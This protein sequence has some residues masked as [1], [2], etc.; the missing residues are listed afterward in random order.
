MI[1]ILSILII[2]FLFFGGFSVIG[3]TENI[4]DNNH[5]SFENYKGCLIDGPLEEWNKTY[6]G[7]YRDWLSYG[8]V[9]NDNS[10]VAKGCRDFSQSYRNGDGWI[11]KINIA[12]NL[13]WEKTI[14]GDGSDFCNG[15][16]QTNN[17]GYV[18]GFTTD[19]F[20]SG[21]FDIRL[22]KTDQEF[23]EEWDIL[24]TSSYDK[25]A[26]NF[27]NANDG[28]F[29]MTG[30]TTN[31]DDD[32]DLLII[33][34]DDSGNEEWNRIF[35]GSDTDG[36]NR[37]LQTDDNGYIVI[38]YTYSYG[39]GNRD[40]WIIKLD[41]A[42][43]E[44]WKRTYGMDF[45]DGLTDIKKTIDGGY[46]ILGSKQLVDS[47]DD[48][49]L[50]KF[51]NEW[52]LEWEQI[53]G[54][55]DFNEI[56]NSIQQT[57]DNGFIITGNHRSAFITG[58][59]QGILL[60]TD[61][62]GVV[63]W[64]KLFGGFDEDNGRYVIQTSDD[65]FIVIGETKSYGSGDID[66]WIVKF[67]SFENQRPNIPSRPSGETNGRTGEE[68][69]Y[70][71]STIDPDGDD[72]YYLFDWGNGMTS[73]IQGPYASGEECSSAGIWF[74]DGNY[75]IKVKAID[76]H[77]AES[78]WSDPLIVSMPKSKKSLINN[79]WYY[80][81]KLQNYAPKGMPDFDQRQE[82]W[83]NH[84]GMESF[85]GPTAVSNVLW[86]IDSKYSDPKGYPGDGIDNYPLVQDYNAPSNP[87]PGPLSDDHNF[88]NVNDPATPWD[89]VNYTYGN[90]F[91]EKVAWYVDN[92]GVKTGDNHL[93]A[94]SNGI[95]DGIT[96]WIQDVGLS[97]SFDIIIHDSTRKNSL[98]EIIN[99][100]KCGD[101]IILNLGFYTNT[102]FLR[103]NHWVTVAGI[104]ES[105]NKIAISDPYVD[106]IN[107]TSDHT[108]HN[109]ANIVSHD[110]FTTNNTS[111]LSSKSSWWLEDYKPNYAPNTNALIIDAII[112]AP[113]IDNNPP[114][115]P[116]ITGPT[117]GKY[118]T[119]YSYFGVSNDNDG[120]Q[121]F[122]LFDWG[123]GST[124]FILGPYGSGIECNTSNIWFNQGE[125]E[126]K[127]KAIDIHNSE[128]EWSDPLSVSMPRS[129]DIFNPWLLRLIQR[130]PILKFLL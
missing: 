23:N 77:G 18:L 128:S 112:I 116:T 4:D 67:S 65:G 25:S 117:S 72:V 62:N 43:N 48:I 1:K 94:T 68:Y 50:L 51:D 29:L 20:G 111:P 99:H 19:S 119:E 87:E 3:L 122:Y 34:T 15:L 42:G 78:D 64:S 82:S 7:E 33:K 36:G 10:I 32:G 45:N 2:E 14:G 26:H 118:E 74:E 38:G 46:I 60:K 124:S 83:R 27:N 106:I 96:Q 12:G 97:N 61:V 113:I 49:W 55:R 54:D 75:E 88:N 59:K 120:D 66:G 52:N 95:Y 125:Y 47:D 41:E 91:I 30:W 70:T 100:I 5:L 16:L 13:I 86:Y 102:G 63:E 31:I 126:V 110:I 21:F 85:C 37:V 105:L 35:G 84:L 28:G 22:V 69:L 80:Y 24:F 90:E 11:I 79:E 92:D 98:N 130:F 8:I 108:A 114:D 101:F 121:L 40:G 107:N 81:P 56:G 123:D 53:I 103:G 17:N 9:L 58:N 89:S 57:S 115:K 104:S 44:V 73:F 93:G 129:I 39:A 76:E 6:G 71:T 127:V 109:D